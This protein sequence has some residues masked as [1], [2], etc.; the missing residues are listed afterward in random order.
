MKKHALPTLAYVSPSTIDA[1]SRVSQVHADS[2][3]RA[4]RVVAR[5]NQFPGIAPSPIGRL[6]SVTYGCLGEVRMG[7]DAWPGVEDRE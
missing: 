4:A 1:A 6:V 2:P 3:T 7:R 5:P